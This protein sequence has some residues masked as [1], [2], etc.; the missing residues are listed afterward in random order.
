MITRPLSNRILAEAFK[1]GDT[2]IARVADNG[3]ALTFETAS[4]EASG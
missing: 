2:I 1:R 3:R 4:V